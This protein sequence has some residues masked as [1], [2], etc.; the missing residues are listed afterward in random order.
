MKGTMISKNSK[1]ELKEA[2]LRGAG[3]VMGR[4]IY[5]EWKEGTGPWLSGD[6]VGVNR[7]IG[8]RQLDCLSGILVG[9]E[10][11]AIIVEVVG[12]QCLHVELA[13]VV[14]G[15]QVQTAPVGS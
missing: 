4:D 2:V 1:P 12:G 15:L 10:E 6:R 3:R 8:A 9:A 5:L 11:G 13:Y 14:T 7:L